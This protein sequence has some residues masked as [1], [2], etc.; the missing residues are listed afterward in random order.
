MPCL[1]LL[2]AFFSPRLAIVA[3]AVFSDVL[4]RSMDGILLPFIGFLVLPWT[5]LAWAFTWNLG[6]N[7]V[8]GF[9]WFVVGLAVLV[10]LGLVGSGARSRRDR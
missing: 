9:E 5:T 10:D 8:A 1:V 7:G 6:T 3:M 2:L 4:S